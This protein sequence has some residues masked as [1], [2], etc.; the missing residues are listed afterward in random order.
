MKIKRI[1]RI[2]ITILIIIIVSN[3]TAIALNQDISMNESW[4]D[5]IGQFLER[6]E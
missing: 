1:V 2:T 3:N 4:Q 6:L 5:K